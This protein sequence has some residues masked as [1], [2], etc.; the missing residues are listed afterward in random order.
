MGKN[1]SNHL[2]LL[3]ITAALVGFAGTGLAA[4]SEANACSCYYPEGFTYQ[5]HV[6]NAEQ[7]VVGKALFSIRLGDRVY[8]AFKPEMDSKG[9]ITQEERTIWIDTATT[10]AECG[11]ELENQERYLVHL[12]GKGEQGTYPLGLCTFHKKVSNLTKEEGFHLFN[13]KPECGEKNT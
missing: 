8:I 13:S 11:V 5:D 6:D 10:G 1:R 7:A 9:C 3:S 2:R 12:N 4:A